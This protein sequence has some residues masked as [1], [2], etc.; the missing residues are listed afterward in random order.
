M[1]LPD[2][3][4]LTALNKS[5]L[6]GRGSRSVAYGFSSIPD[7]KPSSGSFGTSMESAFALAIRRISSID[8]FAVITQ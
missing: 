5:Y 2:A 8:R 6:S 3:G 4:R 1:Y 7:E